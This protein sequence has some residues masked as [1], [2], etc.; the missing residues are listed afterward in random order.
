MKTRIL[1]SLA[2][3]PKMA[4][5]RD[6]ER[7][8]SAERRY[9]LDD[10]VDIVSLDG[11]TSSLRGA[12]IRYLPGGCPDVDSI[13][14]DAELVAVLENPENQL[15]GCVRSPAGRALV[16]SWA[17]GRAVPGWARMSS[18]LIRDCR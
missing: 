8:R 17:A 1:L 6:N 9:W 16:E 14:A 10:R 11:V 7:E 18:G 13:L 12:R 3:L 2:V 4:V 5:H 15:P